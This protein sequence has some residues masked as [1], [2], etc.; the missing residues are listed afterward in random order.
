MNTQ[1]ALGLAISAEKASL[2]TYLRLAWETPETAGKNM[3]LRLAMDELEHMRLL[4]EQLERLCSEGTCVPVSMEPSL[5]EQVVPNLRHDRNAGTRESGRGPSAALLD[6]LDTESRARD[7]YRARAEEAQPG[8][9]RDMF[10]R[11][12]EM[13]LAH[14]DLLQ[15]ELDSVTGTGMW[16]GIRE[17]TLESER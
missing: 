15:A 6:A 8:P 13:E 17:F 3:Y 1:E 9:A 12:A 2:G 11:L 10:A 5:I 4:E 7:F 16:L 14:A